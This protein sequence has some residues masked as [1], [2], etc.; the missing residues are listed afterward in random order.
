MTSGPQQHLSVART[1]QVSGWA[2]II[3]GI[4]WDGSCQPLCEIC[5]QVTI[6]IAPGTIT[7]DSVR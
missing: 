7:A 1:Q 6:E 2:G 3:A 4:V 5:E